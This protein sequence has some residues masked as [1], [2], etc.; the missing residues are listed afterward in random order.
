MSSTQCTRA[1]G[2]K[3]QLFQGARRE[4]G[5]AARIIIFREDFQPRISRNS[6][7]GS[8]DPSTREFQQNQ[9]IT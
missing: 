1:A 4:I 6:R 7:T 5:P 3:Q 8:D 9:Q 2:L